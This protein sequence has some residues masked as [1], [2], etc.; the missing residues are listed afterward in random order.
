MFFYLLL[1]ATLGAGVWVF[2]KRSMVSILV[3]ALL[4]AAIILSYFYL[5]N[6]GQQF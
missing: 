1:A 6:I 3:L 5:R 4:I 2:K